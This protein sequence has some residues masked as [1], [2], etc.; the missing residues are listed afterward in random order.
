MAVV[1]APAPAVAERAVEGD[2]ALG[3][4]TLEVDG[5]IGLGIEA[6][7]REACLA[8]RRH[9]R[10]HRRRQEGVVR[11]DRQVAAIVVAEP[12]VVVPHPR[13]TQLGG[14]L[15]LVGQVIGQAGHGRVVLLRRDQRRQ[16]V[17]RGPFAADRV[18]PDHRAVV[19][20]AQGAVRIEGL[21]LQNA[22]KNQAARRGVGEADIRRQDEAASAI[23]DRGPATD[24]G[25]A[26]LR[27]HAVVVDIFAADHEVAAAVGEALARRRL[28][29]DLLGV[30]VRGL[31]AL[32]AHLQA[33]ERAVDADIDH[34]GH[35][36]GAP[37]RRGPAG[38]HVDALGQDAGDQVQVVVAG[39]AAAVQQHQGAADAQAAQVDGRVTGAGV[40]A[41]GLSRGRGAELRQVVQGR[42][43]VRPRAAAQI[44]GG[45]AH[46]RG[47]RLEV[48]AVDARGRDDDLADAVVFGL[49]G[50]LGQSGA[51]EG[52]DGGNQAAAQQQA[53]A[54]L[55]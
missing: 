18:G 17:V 51:L 21:A 32:D 50:L 10:L 41:G 26:V 46:G 23:R 27:D 29:A 28:Q 43:D 13:A 34:A 30:V 37:G 11:L 24:I 55:A 20:V 42:G 53:P 6:A 5:R 52:Q 48:G 39:E 25:A 31:A 47:R 35:G 49:G 36:A 45:D 33:G 22:R 14:H 40:G 54:G 19:E 16:V 44:L 15:D 9:R 3:R 1:G 8:G 12:D 4:D 2:R 7:H 38:H